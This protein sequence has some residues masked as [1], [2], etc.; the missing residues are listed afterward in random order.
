M[1]SEIRKVAMNVPTVAMALSVSLSQLNIPA[2]YIKKAP[3]GK[4]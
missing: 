4:Q 1:V 2:K 3:D